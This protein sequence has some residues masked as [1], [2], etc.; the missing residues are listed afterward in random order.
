MNAASRRVLLLLL[1]AAGA[2]VGVWAYFFTGSWYRSFPGFGLHW[3][4]V[5]GPYNEHLS[6]DVGALYMALAVLSLGAARRPDNGQVVALTGLTWLVF[7]VPH[8][9]YHMQHL[10]MYNGRDQVLNVI[11]LGAF[12]LA[13]AAL[14]LPARGGPDPRVSGTAGRGGGGRLG[15]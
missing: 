1:A 14:L 3:L 2:Y 9:V 13:G 12:V 5:L 10:D 11:S 15:R 6:K 4:P 8:F 7:S